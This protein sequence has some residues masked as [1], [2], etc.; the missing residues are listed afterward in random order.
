MLTAETFM[1]VARYLLIVVLALADVTLVIAAQSGATTG[2]LTGVV[3]DSSKAVLAGA[4]VTIVNRDTG[5]TRSVATD[6][7]GRFVVAALPVGT[8][9]VRVEHPGFV[10]FA[11]PDLVLRLG[12][13]VDI[14]LPMTVA[15][16]QTEVTVVGDA[17]V[18]D[19]RTAAISNV[20]QQARIDRLPT[21][22]RNFIAFSLI[23]PGVST[24]QTPQQGASRTSGLTFSGQRARSNNITVDGLDNNDE[25]VGSVRALF[26]QEAVKEFQVVASSFPAEFGKASGGLVNIVTKSGT[27]AYAG[28]VFGFF[29]DRSLNAKGRFEQFDPAGSAI[30]QPKAPFNRKQFGGIFGGPIKTNRSFFFVSFERLDSLAS[31]F[32]TID[33]KTPIINPLNPAAV[34]GTPAQILRNAGF[35][36]ETGDVPYD[37][38]FNQ[39]LAKGDVQ[40]AP[41]HSVSVRFNTATELNENIEPFGGLVARSRAA[42]LESTDI[43]AAASDTLV[44][45]SHIVNELRGQVA[46]RN[47]TVRSLDPACGAPCLDES[48]GGP[49]LEV[50]GVASVGRQR[51]T[52]TLRDNVRYQ[53]LDT[54]SYYRGR[55]EFKAGAD[56]S[57]IRGRRQSLPLHFGGRYIFQNASLPL[58]PGVPPIPVTAIQEVALGLPIVYVQGYGFSGLAYNSADL[59]LFAQDRWRLGSTVSLQFGLRYQRQF[60]QQATYQPS[61]YPGAYDFPSDSNNIAPRVAIAW[62]PR[63]DIKTSVHAAYGVFYDNVITSAYGISKYINGTDGVRTLV[64]LAPGAFAAWAAPGHRLMEA[65]ALQLAGGRYPSV[66]ITIDPALKTPYAHHVGVGVDRELP[67]RA[68]VAVNFVVARGFDELGTID[69]N[70]IVPD[71]GAG[72]R[73]ADVNGVRGT[74]ASVLQYT[75]FGET[76]YRGMT[77]SLDK[78]LGQQWQLIAAYTVSKADDTSTDF[79]SAF[80]PQSNGR[81]RNPADPNGLPIG[82]SPN[83]ERG[84]AVQDQRH[85]FVVSGSYDAP[86]GVQISAILNAGSRRP[87]NILA[88]ADLNGDG[89]GG[90][91]PPDRARTTPSDAATSIRRNSGTLPSQVTLDLRVTRRFTTGTSGRFAIEPIFEVFNLLNRTNFTGVQNVF[92]AGSY[93]ANPLSTFGQFTQ[94]GPPR[95]AQVAVKVTF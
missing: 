72:R 27:N 74:S 20:I 45:S 19:T 28:N 84:P 70:P 64:L 65:A 35:P 89:D 8:Y 81:G 48:Q 44:A 86:R 85:R 69:Y 25:T 7:V 12:S 15:G 82:F 26:S 18:V 1:M 47:Q 13:S 67:G 2:D 54:A 75:S 52:P 29:R 77:V 36:V 3:V 78:R 41:T 83:D 90:G 93:P 62:N 21:N 76:W 33:D 58:V 4:A 39:F 30:D 14:E 91:T 34:F 5:L 73:P 9:G 22:G 71:L 17:P 49:T 46:L 16:P 59:S 50:T 6:A 51:F 24:D 61:G 66:A 94:A 79:Q 88:G 53:V 40:L 95:Q 37:I 23:T 60:W 57:I 56:A 92:G 10:P 87:Y 43:M 80:L 63:N 42:A 68:S 32:V 38:V 31:N 55:H 11:A